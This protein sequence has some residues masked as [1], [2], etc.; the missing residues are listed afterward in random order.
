MKSYTVY[1]APD[2]AATDTEKAERMEFIREGFSWLALL[3]PAIWMIY[4]R[5]WIVLCIY[6]AL[7]IVIQS[8]AQFFGVEEQAV[9]LVSIFINIALGFEGNNL[10][11][12]TLENQGYQLVGTVSGN[13]LEECEIKFFSH[14]LDAEHSASDL[15]KI[16]AQT[17][18]GATPANIR[19]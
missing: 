4:N 2:P 17:M 15:T 3:V 19:H 16:A 11:R 1:E 5:L 8:L 6:V 7:I 18:M 14:W 10:R 12:W 13:S 9:G